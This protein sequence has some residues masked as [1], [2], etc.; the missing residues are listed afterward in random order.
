LRHHFTS[1]KY[2][3]EFEAI[4]DS[5]AKSVGKDRGSEVS[6]D[7]SSIANQVTG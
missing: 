1:E 3:I 5:L 4:K 2:E 7:P 6:Q